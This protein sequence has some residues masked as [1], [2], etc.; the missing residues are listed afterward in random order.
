MD[1]Q[2]V[3][4]KVINPVASTDDFDGWGICHKSWVKVCD[5]KRDDL[6]CVIYD[7]EDYGKLWLAYCFPPEGEVNC[8]QRFGATEGTKYVFRCFSTLNKWIDFI[9]VVPRKMKDAAYLL[10]FKTMCNF[11]AKD[12]QTPYGDLLKK[13]FDKFRM[14]YDLLIGSVSEDGNST[15]QNWYETIARLYEMRSKDTFLM[16]TIII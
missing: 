9:V 13:E 12:N 8:T 4:I 16:R 6:I 5:A 7:F 10:I 2:R 15:D 1:G 11:N 3:L 14:E